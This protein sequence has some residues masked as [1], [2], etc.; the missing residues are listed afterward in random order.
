VRQSYSKSWLLIALAALLCAGA[1]Q[2]H[3]ERRRIAAKLT[4]SNPDK[5]AL[6]V[7]LLALG[8]FRGIVADALCCA[9]SASKTTVS[10]T[11]CACWAT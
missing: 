7:G 5:D 1:L 8:G 6:E 9:R 2:R 3:N 4:F 11:T 10:I